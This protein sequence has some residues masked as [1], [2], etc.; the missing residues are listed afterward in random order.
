[1]PP[2]L[3]DHPHAAMPN[4]A[5]RTETFGTRHDVAG[6]PVDRFIRLAELDGTL[7]S[8]QMI[9]DM[10]VI[11]PGAT[12][13]SGL[14]LAVPTFGHLAAFTAAWNEAAPRVD[15]PARPSG[16]DPRSPGGDH[17]LMGLVTTPPGDTTAA[18]RWQPV[19]VVAHLAT[20]VIGLD[21]HPM[22]LDGPAAWGAYRAYI[23]AHGHCSLPPLSD[24]HAVDFAL[25]LATWNMHG[26]WGWACSR[27]HYT[28]AGYTTVAMRRRPAVDEMARYTSDK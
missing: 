7:D 2:R 27:A 26:T 19:R 13:Y 8:V 14:H 21:T 28:P 15:A 16:G 11:K 18:P 22:H 24:E 5:F 25:P 4:G 9:Q 6:T 17:R 20:P 23:A 12:L 1:L 3:A 10:Q